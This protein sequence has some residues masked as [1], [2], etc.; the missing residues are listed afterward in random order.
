LREVATEIF[1]AGGRKFG[2]V[3]ERDALTLKAMRAILH[4][5]HT[6]GETELEAAGSGGMK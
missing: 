4:R 6:S 1:A 5:T 3:E 2:G